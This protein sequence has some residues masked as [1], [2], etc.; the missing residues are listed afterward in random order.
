[1][2]RGVIIHCCQNFWQVCPPLQS[3][4]RPRNY[5]CVWKNEQNSILRVT[6]LQVWGEGLWKFCGWIGA[7]GPEEELGLCTEALSPMVK[8]YI[9][10][11]PVLVGSDRN[12]YSMCIREKA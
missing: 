6:G 9:P 8:R 4:A 12:P 11:S 7:H 1:M 2:I 5:R 3:R 10:S